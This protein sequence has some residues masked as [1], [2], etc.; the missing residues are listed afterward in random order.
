[1]RSLLNQNADRRFA[2]YLRDLGHVVTVVGVDHP[3]GLPDADVLA[4]GHREGRVIITNDRDFGELG[5]R[6]RTPHAGVL[7]LRLYSPD[8]VSKRDRL[9]AVLTEYADRLDQ[10]ITVTERSVRVR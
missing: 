8:F 10:F 1:M 2:A 7:Y 9:S 6:Q 4:I 3:P 5:F